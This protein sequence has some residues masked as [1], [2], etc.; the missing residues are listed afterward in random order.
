MCTKLFPCC[1]SAFQCS[2]VAAGDNM[3]LVS[4][5]AWESYEALGKAAYKG[6]V[7]VAQTPYSATHQTAMPHFSTCCWLI[8]V[9]H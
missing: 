5:S 9:C 7:L 4:Y 6:A 2:V 1:L 8:G 3:L